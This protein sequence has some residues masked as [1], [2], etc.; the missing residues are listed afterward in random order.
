MRQFFTICSFLFVVA[1]SANAEA[2]R[3]AVRSGDGATPEMVKLAISWNAAGPNN[4]GRVFYV[5][6]HV[7]TPLPEGARINRF[8][9]KPDG[10]VV[11]DGEG[12][13]RYEEFVVP[14]GQG[15]NVWGAF[16]W[17]GPFPA[18][19]QV[20]GG[21]FVFELVVKIQDK[22][23]RAVT[24]VPVMQFP[25]PLTGP[26]EWAVPTA[27]G[28]VLLEGSFTTPF[29]VFPRWSNRA[30]PVEGSFISLAGTQ[31]SGETDLIVCSAMSDVLWECSSQKVYIPIR[32]TVGNN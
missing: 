29:A 4:P 26:L 17:F 22:E 25:L 23:W 30:V 14:P 21:F 12:G 2:K 9:W 24:R 20:S 6:G 11:K 31:I 10:S 15:G 3:H 28:G 16:F 18:E 13:F 7:L 32:Y 27:D 8:I 19:W 1:F 5:W